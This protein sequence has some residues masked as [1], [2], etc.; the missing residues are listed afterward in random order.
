[1]ESA[2]SSESPPPSSSNHKTQSSD[3]I[4][5][6]EEDSF[7]DSG[8]VISDSSRSIISDSEDEGSLHVSKVFSPVFNNT[9][10]TLGMKSG[11]VPFAYKPKLNIP[12]KKVTKPLANLPVKSVENKIQPGIADY[13]VP[14][15][16]GATQYIEPKA[17][18]VATVT[19]Q[20]SDDRAARPIAPKP[21]LYSPLQPLPIKKP[22]P[23]FERSGNVT[24]IIPIIK[25]AKPMVKT[26][27]NSP[28]IEIEDDDEN[29]TAERQERAK[30]SEKILTLKEKINQAS[31]SIKVL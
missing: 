29:D 5:L 15:A 3:V 22:S 12:A 21:V 17:S 8:S 31:V 2:K 10:K 14:K 13:V 24:H 4:D 11:S 19:S 9:N 6:T 20:S 23:P 30:L 16:K 26:I 1:M 27:M 28:A 18:F 25:P 7:N